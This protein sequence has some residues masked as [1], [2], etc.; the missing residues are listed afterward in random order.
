MSPSHTPSPRRPYSPQPRQRETPMSASRRGKE[1]RWQTQEM[2]YYSALSKKEVPPS[3][4]RRRTCRTLRGVK[5]Q[6]REDRCRT[7]PPTR[8]INESSLVV[9]RG[10]QR[11]GP[12]WG[13][14]KGDKASAPQRSESWDLHKINRAGGDFAKMQTPGPLTEAE[15]RRRGPEL[16]V[17]AM[18]PAPADAGSSLGAPVRRLWPPSCL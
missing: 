9:T 18:P 4:T 6:T 10:N 15:P 17:P 13:G 12:G 2:E 8:S 5:C 11:M 3:A 16:G 7:S 1:T 14:G